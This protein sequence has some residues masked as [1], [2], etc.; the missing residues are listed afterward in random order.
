MIV[1][2]VLKLI[3]IPTRVLRLNSSLFLSTFSCDLRIK[4]NSKVQQIFLAKNLN[5]PQINTNI[6]R[7]A[8]N[9]NNNNVNKFSTNEEK[10]KETKSSW[11]DTYLPSK[12]VPYALLARLDKPIGTWLLY[13]PCS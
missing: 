11:I 10:Y 7:F 5:R 6:Y 1:S 4:Q 2:R 12:L 13:L 8:S 9:I 3:K